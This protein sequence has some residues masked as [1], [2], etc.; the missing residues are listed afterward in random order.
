MTWALAIIGI[1][2]LI[3][4]HEAGHALVAKWCGMRVERFSLFFPPILGRKRIG[5]TEF[6]IGSIPLGGY[7]RIAG[8]S[9]DDVLPEGQEHRSYANRPVWQRMAVIAAGPAANIAAAV[10]LISAILMFSGVSRVVPVIGA[11]TLSA[12]AAGVLKPGDRIVSVDGVKGTPEALV[13][14]TR[15][16]RCRGRAVDGC[17]ASR[18]AIVAYSRDGVVRVVKVSPRF[19]SSVAAM[20]LGFA[21]SVEHQ[22]LDP[23]EAIGRS[24]AIAWHVSTAAVRGFVAIAT[25]EGRRQVS[26]IVGVSV[27]TQQA[28]SE[29]VVYALE[30]LAFISLLIAIV[31]LFPI[32]PL[33]GGHLFW[34]AIEKIRGR[35]VSQ[36][37]LGR[38]TAVGLVLVL[39]LFLVGLSNDI[40]RLDGSGFSSLR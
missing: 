21:F 4:I 39:G 38:A 2:A 19:D 32:L 30:L 9:P 12:P 22:K 35:A 10:L 27:V 20:R 40:G 34:L 11:G 6:T 28:F 33:D 3:V 36:E 18:P 7:V 15:S 14:Q 25:P 17:T 16:H 13:R 29:D 8:Q 26:G 37:V 5:E 23:I 31:N 1:A 24:V